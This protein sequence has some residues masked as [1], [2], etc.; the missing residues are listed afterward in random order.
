M[1][2][3]R[4]LEKAARALEQTERIHRSPAQA[5]H[6][7]GRSTLRAAVFDVSARQTGLRQVNQSA[8]AQAV[9]R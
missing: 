6:H 8:G 1:G 7:Q 2:D 3:E 5:A 4:M 9:C